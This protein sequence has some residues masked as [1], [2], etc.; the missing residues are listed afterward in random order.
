MMQ[1]KSVIILG[2]SSILLQGCAILGFKSTPW[3][4]STNIYDKEALNF[5][6]QDPAVDSNLGKGL[7]TRSFDSDDRLIGFS[8]SG[9]GSRAT[10]FTL[11][12][13]AELQQ[14][15][16]DAATGETALDRIDFTSSVSGGGWAIALYLAERMRDEEFNLAAEK[17]N[18]SERLADET[19]GRLS[20]WY[21]KMKVIIGKEV[22][23]AKNVTFATIY[24]PS[25]ETPLPA[26][27]FNAAILPSQSA[28]VFNDQFISDYK[29]DKFGACGVDLTEAIGSLADVPLAYAATAS[30]SVPGFYSAHA[31]T[32][33]CDDANYREA[34]FCHAIKPKNK[35]SYLRIADGGLYDNIGYKTAFEVMA[36]Q[37]DRA[38]YRQR[39]LILVNS[40][41]TLDLRTVK[42]SDRKS[43]FFASM[44]KNGTFAVQDSTF[45]RFA[46]NIAPAMG[47]KNL[48]LLDFK[49][50][51]GFDIAKL[52]GEDI[53]ELKYLAYYAAHKVQCYGQMKKPTKGR[54]PNSPPPVAES[55]TYLQETRKG[56]CL[57][58]NFYR[59]GN[60]NK[61]S[62]KFDP[63][64]F[65]V[66][67]ELG[68]LSVKMNKSDI[69]EALD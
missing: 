41:A 30:A 63:V 36:S 51:S 1:S 20:C 67:W 64:L 59:S 22:S 34:S 37:S 6:Q 61:T 55:L 23:N 24:N 14:I 50:T 10:A 17:E 28:F 33:L 8:T 19:Q 11:G 26:A 44:A 45:P 62:Y 29:V 3:P 2:L 21:P 38:K 47:I 39:T 27:Y 13:M 32:K 16:L 60:L 69:I 53:S 43:S 18:I 35:R 31:K 12:V 5:L 56:D 52:K 4:S 54:F 65:R 49:S 57:A 40:A 9:G 48:I 58:E 68:Q 7:K 42:E 25:R 15:E 46:K 66:L